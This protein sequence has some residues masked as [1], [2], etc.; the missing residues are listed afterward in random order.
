MPYQLAWLRD[1]SSS[2]L[3]RRAHA[4]VL[5][6]R[7]GGPPPG[8]AGAV[9]W[10]LGQQV[11]GVLPS[12][13]GE[14]RPSAAATAAAVA[15]ASDY[16]LSE[17]AARW[18]AW[19]THQ[20][21]TDGWL[22]GDGQA[23]SRW[24]TAEVLAAMARWV[25]VSSPAHTCSLRAAAAVATRLE[26]LVRPSALGSPPRELIDRADLAC[27]A[28]LHL[29]A[30]RLRQAVWQN[31]ARE[32]AAAADHQSD[33]THWDVPLELQA[34]AAAAFLELG[35]DALARQ[36]I[37]Q[38]LALST[39]RG[40]C[41]ETPGGAPATS[42]GLAR[43]ALVA[44]DLQPPIAQRVM[45]LLRSRQHRSG[46]ML[47]PRSADRTPRA[48][49]LA[50]CDYLRAQ[51]TEAAQSFESDALRL[52][53]VLAPNDP[54]WIAARDWVEGLPSRA[55]VADVGCGSGRFLRAMASLRPDLRLIGVDP[56]ARLLAQS[57]ASVER[58]RGSMLGLPLEAHS[59]DAALAVESLEHSLLPRPAAAELCRVLRPEGRLLIVDKQRRY[60]LRSDHEPWERWPEPSELRAWLSDECESFEVNYFA[61]GD[62][63]A[64]R[65]LFFALRAVRRRGG[66]AGLTARR[67]A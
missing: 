25:W 32:V 29:V 54:L 31:L 63:P 66:Q 49:M 24:V 34:R 41:P 44:F 30:R 58:R 60:Q 33:W 39:R 50:T 42:R 15:A 11:D 28:A 19:L 38:P 6:W 22:P 67:A 2:A 35:Q 53:D 9:E 37:A 10:L 56:A 59:V 3:R 18:I 64:R 55:R 40:G 23:I 52:P 17:P 14:R 48:S 13:P 26:R 43:L 21:R 5:A 45:A 61:A 4:I 57:P 47:D 16:Q 46:A 27:A 51:F 36:L 20:Q 1:R 7:Y 8:P 65:D 12:A 62:R